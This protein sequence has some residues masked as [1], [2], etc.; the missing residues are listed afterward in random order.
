M[1]WLHSKFIGI[2]CTKDNYP[3]GSEGIPKAQTCLSVLVC[4]YLQWWRREDPT[5]ESSQPDPKLSRGAGWKAG[6]R[7]WPA[8]SGLRL[9]LCNFLET[10]CLLLQT[11]ATIVGRGG[12]GKQQQRQKIDRK[13]LH[14][15]NSLLSM[16]EE[17]T[18]KIGNDEVLF[19]I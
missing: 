8:R 3:V 4:L 10:G 19:N 13:S 15:C 18:S 11:A 12:G 6:G 14:A 7:C 1:W 9:G 16:N 2:V 5:S 17:R